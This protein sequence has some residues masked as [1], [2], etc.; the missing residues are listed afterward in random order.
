MSNKSPFQHPQ[1]KLWTF[2]FGIERDEE[3]TQSLGELTNRNTNT[4]RQPNKMACILQM[5]RDVS[6]FSATC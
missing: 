2:W 6:D 1:Q 3:E 5:S 4:R